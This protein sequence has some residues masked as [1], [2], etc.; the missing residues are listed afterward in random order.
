MMAGSGTWHK[1][2]G[3]ESEGISTSD[4]AKRTYTAHFGW[5]NDSGERM[6]KRKELQRF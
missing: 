3:N 6:T 2:T 4:R 5:N 1:R